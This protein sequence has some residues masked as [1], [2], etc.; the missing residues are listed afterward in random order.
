MLGL[1]REAHRLVV[2]RN[3][4]RR[5]EA[6]FRGIEVLS[7]VLRTEWY[8]RNQ[9]RQLSN[10]RTTCGPLRARCEHQLKLSKALLVKPKFHVPKQAL[11]Q[12]RRDRPLEGSPSRPKVSNRGSNSQLSSLKRGSSQPCKHHKSRKT[13]CS[14]VDRVRLSSTLRRPNS[15]TKST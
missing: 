7:V 11:R 5:L 12:E 4:S 13:P 15:T 1:S 3:K 14:K 8:R 2:S 9:R 10:K 6:L